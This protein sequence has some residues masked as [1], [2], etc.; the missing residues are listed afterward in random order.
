MFKFHLKLNWGFVKP[1]EIISGND[2]DK[3]CSKRVQENVHVA[4]RKY[5]TEIKI[6]PIF[7][8]AHK[9]LSWPFGINAVIICIG[10][11]YVIYFIY[12]QKL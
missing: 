9:Y 3:N 5:W 7:S 4:L 1:S 11:I 10:Y 6:K 12:V 8:G 2:P